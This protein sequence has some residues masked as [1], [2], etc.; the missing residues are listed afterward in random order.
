MVLSGFFQDHLRFNAKIILVY[1]NK[2]DIPQKF[3]ID[4][5]QEI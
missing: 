3:L 1:Q 4:L 5:N 2:I